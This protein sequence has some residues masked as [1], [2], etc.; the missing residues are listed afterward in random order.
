MEPN[1]IRFM[2]FGHLYDFILIKQNWLTIKNISNS[3]RKRGS[4][5]AQ[6]GPTWVRPMR[7]SGPQQGSQRARWH[8][9]KRDLI[10]ALNYITVF[11]L[12]LS[13]SNLCT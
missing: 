4:G 6:R 12:F 3:L 1:K 7:G 9:Y 5:L 13:L 10:L 11:S 8:F 2:I